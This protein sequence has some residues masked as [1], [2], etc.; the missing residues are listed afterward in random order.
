MEM[1]G[2]KNL[3]RAC[4]CFILCLKLINNQKGW[5][6]ENILSHS[7]LLQAFCLLLSFNIHEIACHTLIEKENLF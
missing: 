4:A 1:K 3:F 7:V 2:L 5:A 6:R